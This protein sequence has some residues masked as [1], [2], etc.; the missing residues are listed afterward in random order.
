MDIVFFDGLC[1]LC[2]G[3]VDFLIRHDK[4]RKL[5]FS[6]LQGK[7]IRKTK[8][9]PLA[10]EQTIIF[11]KGDEIFA[12]SKAAIEC[13]ASLGGGWVLVKV[14]LVIPVFIRDGVYRFI[15]KN[16]YEWFGKKDSCR[17]LKEEE[18]PYFLE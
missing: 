15:A 16:R 12:R 2:N 4:R 5:F 17:I 10:G 18:K 8:A 7:T 9:A 6:P 13:I 14:F 11:L 3:F 1:S